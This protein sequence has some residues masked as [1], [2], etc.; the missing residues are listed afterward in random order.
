MY[1][2]YNEVK[3]LGLC[4]R[5]NLYNAS[6]IESRLFLRCVKLIITFPTL[7]RNGNYTIY[8]A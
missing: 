3:V 6:G 1:Y 4:M 8:T 2:E 7:P 5:N